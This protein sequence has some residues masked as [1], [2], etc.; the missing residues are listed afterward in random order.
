VLIAGIAIEKLA[1][2]SPSPQSSPVKGEEVTPSPSMGEGW[3]EGVAI[4]SQ[5]WLDIY[6]EVANNEQTA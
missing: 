1:K 6:T 3:D 2:V 4:H 5:S